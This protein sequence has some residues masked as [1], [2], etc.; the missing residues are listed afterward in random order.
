MPRTL[1][2][3]SLLLL[4]SWPTPAAAQQH[5][6]VTLIAEK[7]SLVPGQPVVLGVHFEI[8]PHWHI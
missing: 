7:A 2:I 8:D 1:V 4:T 5:A 3:F 6:N